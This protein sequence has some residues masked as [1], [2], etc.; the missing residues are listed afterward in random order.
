MS[1]SFAFALPLF[2]GDLG[3]VVGLFLAGGMSFDETEPIRVEIPRLGGHG[4]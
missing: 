2:S 4:G 1:T 3:R